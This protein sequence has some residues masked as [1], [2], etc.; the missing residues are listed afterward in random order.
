MDNAN[1][2][3]QTGLTSLTGGM[4][5]GMEKH[6]CLQ[7]LAMKK[8][9]NSYISLPVVLNEYVFLVLVEENSEVLECLTQDSLC[10]HHLLH[11]GE[12][13]RAGNERS[14]Q[15]HTTAFQ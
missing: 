4:K 3:P 1:L 2:C 8:K 13:V 9:K 14:A 6:N 11:P 5:F 15:A 7:L 12:N 10:L